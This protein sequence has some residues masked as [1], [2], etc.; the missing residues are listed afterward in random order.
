MKKYLISGRFFCILLVFSAMFFIFPNICSAE[1][2]EDIDFNNLGKYL[3]L[4]PEYAKNLINTLRDSSSNKERDF[5]SSLNSS[6]DELA[7][8]E[9]F[10]DVIKQEIVNYLFVDFPVEIIRGVVDKIISIVRIF[11][12]QDVSQILGKIEKET[13]NMAVNY[14]I[15]FLL[16][17][18]IK[19]APGAISYKYKSYK[20]EEK[21]AV[22]QYVVAYKA[23]DNKS[24]EVAIKF[25]SPNIIEDVGLLARGALVYNK[26]LPPFIIDIKGRVKDYKWSETPTININFPSD[27]PDLSIKPLSFWGKY[28]LNPI[29][30]TI[31]D[32][33]II[34]TKITG[35][36]P[37]IIKTWEQIKSF[38]LKI[39]L[40][41]PA[42]IVQPSIIEEIKE[43]EEEI[44]DLEE[45]VENEESGQEEEKLSLEEIQEILDDIAEKI[46][47]LN[48]EIAELNG[49]QYPLDN[50]E[51]I[52]TEDEELSEETE[53]K[54]TEEDDKEEIIKEPDGQ[55]IEQNL[56]EKTSNSLPARSK[57]II[58]EVA[59]M[60]NVD[61][62]NN[63][64]IELK[65]ISGNEIKL[66]G[67]QLLDKENQ[68]K[69]IFTDKNRI[70]FNNF[71]LLERTDDN[72]V[73]GVIA[74]LIYMGGLGNANEALY[75]FDENCRLQDEVL[76]NPNWLAGDNNS[77]RTMERR[78]DL[79]WQTSLAPGGTPKRENSS[80]Y[81][82]AVIGGGGG[83]TP[84]PS[85]QQSSSSEPILC[86]VNNATPVYSPIIFNE[87]AWMGSASSSADE[88]I[89]LKNISTSTVSLSNWQLQGVK[90]GDNNINIK[91]FFSPLDIINSNSYFLLER[92]DDNSVPGILADKIF[93]GSI[94]DSEFILRLFNEYCILIDEV[95]AT[96]TWSAGQNDAEKRTMERKDDLSW[97]TSSSTSS[98]GGLYG[99]P[100]DQNSQFFSQPEN[101]KPLANFSFSSHNLF[102][103]NEVFFDASSSTDPDGVIT[104]YSWNFG[105]GVAT[106]TN[107]ATTTHVYIAPDNFI[108]GLKV[109]DDKG[110]ESLLATTTINIT[111][112]ETSTLSVVINEIAWMG[113]S[114]SNTADEW[115]E[116]YNN[117]NSAVDITGW[118]LKSD[119]GTPLI[120]FP[121]STIPAYEFYL[122]ERTDD[123]TVSDISADSVYTGALENS[124]EKIELRNAGSILI[125]YIDCSSGWFAGT[126]NPIF[127]SME[128][129][130][131]NI[132]GNV[133]ENWANNNLIVRNGKDVNGNNING[134]PRSSNSFSSSNITISRLPFDDLS[135]ITL[136]YSGSPYIITDILYVL[137]GKTLIIEPGVILKFNR[138]AGLEI[139]GTLKAIGEEDKKIIFT[140]SYSV[141]DY[142]QG[143]YFTSSSINSEINWAEIKYGRR[144]IGESPA[145]LV[146]RSSIILKNSLLEN[147]TDRGLK[148]INSSSTVEKTNFSGGGISFSTV[149]IEIEGGSPIVKDCGSIRNNKHG[150]YV[151]YLLGGDLPLIEGNNL[152]ENGN[153][154]FSYNP[155][156]IFKN[157]RA[158][159][160]N[161]VNGILLLS[162]IT[163]NIT[164]FKNELP[165]VIGTPPSIG[166]SIGVNPGVTLTINP[167][168]KVEFANGATLEVYGTLLSRG[169]AE[170]PIIYTAYPG[171]AYW[172]RI[173]FG[174]SSVGSVLDNVIVSYGGGYLYQ[175]HIYVDKSSIEFINSTSTNAV[176]A[177]IYL[178]D[179]TSII[180]NSYFGNAVFGIK[181]Y[182]SNNFPQIEEGIILENNSVKDIYINDKS[183]WC[184]FLPGYLATSTS[185][186][187]YP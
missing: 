104:N 85:S 19:I 179:S 94:N 90:T 34:I 56:C 9:I 23:F 83:N 109:I 72:S 159:R 126:S 60:G 113:T 52:L 48:Q 55:K 43:V 61:S 6:E 154:I 65:N 84:P 17:G 71:Y 82:E 150:I 21:T 177:S 46:D 58:N 8:I 151:E 31:K 132:G 155:N 136:T 16:Q 135:E 169:T 86:L 143:I 121:T 13:V 62:A 36:S 137:V 41:S 89:E 101:Q 77:K 153:A 142:W 24:G 103:G 127:I 42:A 97:H 78:A 68:I 79:N 70:S 165:Y 35:K 152:E 51:E 105:D 3:E 110:E 156:I 108:I 11:L 87:I 174:P 27:V 107:R 4:S 69:I 22:L 123:N 130:N 146:D 33:E 30:T 145:I 63:E 176:E 170:E 95:K 81:I 173:Y 116:L 147:Y 96:S 164:W 99:T 75:L 183:K 15:D 168:V 40:F 125:D 14:G 185:N 131:S 141:P 140:T 7:A 139:S 18:E 39:N 100:K 73:T 49:N 187:C 64:W 149:G 134:T 44:V 47:V 158:E 92:T 29:K 25:Y 111:T 32:A 106:T 144:G 163:Q 12:A 115:I 114:A 2:I 88:W 67:W 161:Q 133:R 91:I 10:T 172:K 166:N 186:N 122:L 184:S 119:D 138:N 59:W 5:W 148:L 80:G 28:L 175:G 93:T 167:G 66:T 76:T 57:V 124:G 102:V 178:E 45:K 98:T 1:N 117:S 50:N 162:N 160:D 120:I 118:T 54:I 37:S 180:R 129:I 38:F 20:G 157:N 171:E 112:Q 53:E 74:D 181:I 26:D 128:R 182:G